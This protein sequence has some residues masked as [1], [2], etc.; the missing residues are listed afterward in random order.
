[1]TVPKKNLSTLPTDD[2]KKII[3][4]KAKE[5]LRRGA[6]ELQ[7]SQAVAVGSTEE[8]DRSAMVIEPN[9]PC[10]IM[11]SAKSLIPMA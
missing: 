11:P 5:P 1:M 4:E 3:P 10:L 9:L 7:C 8:L 2:M 6:L